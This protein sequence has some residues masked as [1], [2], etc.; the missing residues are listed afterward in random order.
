VE[1]IEHLPPAAHPLFYCRQRYTLNLTRPDMAA[2]GFSPSVRLFEAAACSAPVISD[3]WPGIETFFIPGK[4]VLLA[5]STDAVLRVLKEF[6][7]RQRGLVGAAARKRAL[8]EHTAVQRATTLEQ[9]Y[10][11]AIGSHSSNMEVAEAVS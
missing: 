8:Q 9:H 2:A 10:R 6:P 7:E 4:E 5:D 11:E 3:S 1:L